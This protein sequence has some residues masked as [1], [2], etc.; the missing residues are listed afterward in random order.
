MKSVN[1]FSAAMLACLALLAAP[2]V[3][4]DH[5]EKS[6]VDREKM[7]ASV[8]EI[9]QVSDPIFDQ[10]VD[11]GRMDAAWTFLDAEALADIGI[12]LAEAERIL[13]RKHPAISS[14]EVLKVAVRTAGVTKKTEVLDTISKYADERSNE[15]L[16][17]QVTVAK[18]LA[19]MTR[20]VAP[21]L[22]LDDVTLGA[23]IAYKQAQ[24]DL[25]AARVYGS[26]A[27]VKDL[28]EQLDEYVEK[29]PAI[30]TD[31]KK[32]V[33][34]ELTVM[35]S[36]GA[37]SRGGPDD[38]EGATSAMNQLVGA[39]R[40]FPPYGPPGGGYRPPG[41]YS[42]P[43]GYYQGGGGYQNTQINAWQQQQVR[44]QRPGAMVG[45][46]AMLGI[47]NALNQK[48]PQKHA[49]ASGI[50]GALGQGMIMSSNPTISTQGGMNIRQSGGSY[51]YGGGGFN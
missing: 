9:S 44:V 22:S 37:P 7:Q 18:Q 31:L 38:V 51:Q 14:E 26:L 8:D 49:V 15:K 41:G 29:D 42:P 36:L 12:R 17:E 13:F 11:L 25:N 27:M 47:A 6:E 46:S 3:Y 4:A 20:S 39:S 16:Q 34:E 40:G 35:E 2:T 21:R 50:L 48:N 1:A 23:F 10:Y 19:G 30:W 33:D 5:H 32:Q 43:G 45:G 24:H 28:K